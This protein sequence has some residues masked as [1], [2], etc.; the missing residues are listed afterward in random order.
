MFVNINFAHKEQSNFA[1]K[2]V[3][4]K[5]VTQFDWEVTQFEHMPVAGC[6]PEILR[7]SRQEVDKAGQ[8]GSGSGGH[9]Q[10]LL[11][12]SFSLHKYVALLKHVS[13]SS[14]AQSKT[15]ALYLQR[16]PVLSAHLSSPVRVESL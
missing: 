5:A 15:S 1:W 10:K 7:Y 16:R 13:H 9:R 2:S 14:L 8:E 12:T 3:P 4:T 11:S 6:A